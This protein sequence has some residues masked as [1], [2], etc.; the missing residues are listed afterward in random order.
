[1]HLSRKAARRSDLSSP[2]ANRRRAL[3][4]IAAVSMLYL[5]LL[6]LLPKEAFWITD[7]GNKYI[8]V[9]HFART[10]ASGVSI[11]YPAEKIDPD[12]EF[13]P[14][15]GHHFHKRNGK[16]YSFYPF[17]FPLV[18]VPP[19]RLFGP[20]G[21]YVIP[22]LSSIA[23]FFVMLGLFRQVNLDEAGGYGILMLSLCTPFFFYSLT[24]WEHSLAT[25]LGV[26]GLVLILKSETVRKSTA[27]LLMGGVLLGLSTVFREEG[28]ILFICLLIGYALSCGFSI[29]ALFPVLG[30]LFIMVPVWIIQYQVFDHI[31][32]IH[33]AVYAGAMD[34]FSV[35]SLFQACLEKLSDFYTYLFKITGA[36]GLNL[37]LVIPFIV[38]AAAGLFRKPSKTDAYLRLG[39]LIMAGVSGLI[40]AALVTTNEQPVIDT[41]NTQSIFLT[42]P[43]T[44][45]WLLGLRE[46]LFG[47]EKNMRLVAIM[48]TGTIVITCLMLH[49][50]G[51]GIIWGP[52]HFMGIFPALVVLS[53]WGLRR[54][55]DTAI[56]PAAKQITVTVFIGMLLASL[57]IQIHGIRILYLKKNGTQKMIEAIARLE[58]DIVATDIYWFPE[59]VAGLYFKKKWLMIRSD[60]KA[61]ALVGRLQRNN[62]KKFALVTSKYYSR[63]SEKTLN[64]ITK[65]VE[66]VTDIRLKKL[67]FMAVRVF[68]CR[69]EPEP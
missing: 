61:L 8:Q 37:I 62:I 1:M 38:A 48:T 68:L 9:Q 23:C 63:I 66:Q 34:G 28:Y 29:K 43:F 47:T 69:L 60:E 57:V 16:I 42:A 56:S 64:E 13:F 24:F 15:G 53:I 12:R 45:F 31:L 6:C 58:T 7:G 36:T 14:Y 65:S 52:R 17:Y 55:T 30:W 39:I 51:M 20:A 41:L 54:M 67:D 35:L 27:F 25:L 44:A 33:A 5:L 26:I 50:K 3:F 46:S 11:D 40:T 22:L 4:A 59:E 19:Y 10:G 21:L 32:G 18:S 49:Q 2:R